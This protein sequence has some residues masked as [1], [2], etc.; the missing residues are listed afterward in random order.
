MSDNEELKFFNYSAL[1]ESHIAALQADW[2]KYTKEK[3]HYEGQKMGV[4]RGIVITAGGLK[5]FTSAYVLIYTLR[6]L[7]CTLPIEIWHHGSELSRRMCNQLKKFGV[8]CFNTEKYVDTRPQGF[9]MKPLSILYSNFKEVLFLD[10][11][12]VCLRDPSYL[13][14]D[15]KYKEYGCIFWPDYWRTPKQN[16]I[17]SVIDVE[18]LSCQEQES[19]QIL[20]DK[21]RSWNELQLCLYFNMKGGDYYKLMHGDKDTFRFAWMALKSPY[22]MV[23]FDVGSC[24]VIHADS[25]CGNTMVQH[26]SEGEILF[27]HRNLL[28]WDITFK[29]ERAWKIIK[30]FSSSDSRK[31]C[32]FKPGFRYHLAT[33]LEGD[34]YETEFDERFPGFEE[35]CLKALEKLRS[36]KFYKEELLKF[37]LLS[38]RT[39]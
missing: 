28:K 8:K 32:H 20:I 24:G 29:D 19:G 25:F 23:P 18:F 4:G 37:Y 5:Y 39:T 30:R 12:N 26:D 14:E 11:D 21:S 36:T 34:T 3:K 22:Y 31:Y 9:L 16:P 35:A 10:A 13:F 1:S 2:K 15:D 6:S 7:G 33:D 17:W 27:M 38:S